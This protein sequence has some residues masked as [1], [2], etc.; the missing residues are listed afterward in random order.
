M[1][2]FNDGETEGNDK[3]FTNGRVIH[4]MRPIR[5]GKI[6][7]TNILPIYHFF[8][9]RGLPIE[10]INQIPTKLN[11]K[12]LDGL[13]DIGP[14]SAYAY[15]KDASKYYLVPDMSISARGAVRSIFLFS[16]TPLLSQLDGA[17][18]ALTTASATSIHLLRIILEL[19]EGIQ[20][21]YLSLPPNLNQMMQQADA[22][23]L[24]GDDALKA[25]F[26]D[27]GYYPFDLGY[28]WYLRTKLSMTYAV[29]A[30]RRE[31]VEDRKKDMA[32]IIRAFLTAKEKGRQDLQPVIQVAKGQLGGS[33]S[34]WTEY[35][36]GLCYDLK[37]KELSGLKKFYALCVKL[38][39]LQSEVDIQFLDG[40]LMSKSK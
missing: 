28:E 38:G 18:I 29:W 36:S 1:C 19:Y 32:P 7:Y 3:D 24:I 34:F 31:I 14:I 10:W 12:M 6:A 30:I 11:Q 22:A 13:I 16:R 17:K 15:A 33:E 20:P 21:N 35:F 37:D 40:I 25:S 2:F 8:E 4:I 9:D 26:Q 5:I 39:L 23:L 27:H